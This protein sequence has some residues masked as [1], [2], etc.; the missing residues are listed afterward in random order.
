MEYNTAIPIY[1]QVM[2]SIKRD[3]VT[4]RIKP[5]AKLPSVRDLALQY[6]INPN[7]VS[8]VYR[9][10]ETEELCFTRRGM[11]TFVTEDAGR[12][13]KLREDMAQ[14]LVREFLAGIRQLGMTDEEAL[15]LLKQYRER[16]KMTGTA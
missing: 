10:L 8:R 2:T 6:S 9:E 7:T 5:G 13:E 12:V 3:I 16:E 1:L 11:G 14:E 15:Q 4:G